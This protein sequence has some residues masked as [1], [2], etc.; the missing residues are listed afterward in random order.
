MWLNLFRSFLRALSA[1]TTAKRITVALCYPDRA[2]L[3][4]LKDG[5]VT[6]L[7]DGQFPEGMLRTY[8]TKEEDWLISATEIRS[9]RS[10]VAPPTQETYQTDR[11][12]LFPVIVGGEIYGVLSLTDFEDLDIMLTDVHYEQEIRTLCRRA[13]DALAA[14]TA[15]YKADET[16]DITSKSQ[17]IVTLF[18]P[19]TMVSLNRSS[20]ISSFL[21][22]LADVLNLQMLYFEVIPDTD[23]QLRE[24]G[25]MRLMPIEARNLPQDVFARWHKHPWR[26]RPVNRWSPFALTVNEQKVSHLGD[27]QVSHRGLEEATFDIFRLTKVRTLVSIPITHRCKIVGMLCLMHDQPHQSDVRKGAAILD[28]PIKCLTAHFELLESRKQASVGGVVPQSGSKP[29]MPPRQ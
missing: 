28:H 18:M 2:F 4:R 25:V 26:A 5:I 1:A 27:I 15:K 3:Y 21:Q 9:R 11:A 12:A 10:K 13:V 23:P 16:T 29:P 14:L 6:P 19:R 7:K 8:Q 17:Q 24:N 22:S 20:A